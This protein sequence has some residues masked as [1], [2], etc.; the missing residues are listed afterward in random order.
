MSWLI[1][2][3]YPKSCLGCGRGKDYLCNFCERKIKKAGLRQKSGFEGL[4]SIY[5][6]DGL[7]KKIIEEIKYQHLSAGIEILGE[8]MA[9][10]LKIDYPQTVAHWQKEKFVLVPIPLYKGR[11]NWRG[12]NQAGEIAMVL[13]PKLG[14]EYKEILERKK[15]GVHLARIHS[16]QRRMAEIKGVFGVKEG[17]EK[18]AKIILVDDV[19]TSGATM[20]E[21]LK[22]WKKRCPQGRGW[23][24]SLA[25]VRR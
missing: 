17:V 5:K 6:Y 23:G 22:T 3:L 1:D 12:F 20:T 18:E 21:A 25:G 9:Q 2:W 8:K 4:I 24:L 11:E 19:I 13:S 10:S 15:K 14:L 16:H 7:M